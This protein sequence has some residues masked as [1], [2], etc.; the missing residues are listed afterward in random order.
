MQKHT[1]QGETIDC[2]FGSY[3]VLSGVYLKCETGKVVGLLG[4]NGSGKSTL[5]KVLFG[6]LQSESGTVRWNGQYVKQAFEVQNLIKFMS[7]QPGIP[8]HLTFNRLARLLK[9]NG[10]NYEWAMQNGFISRHLN[11]PFHKVSAGGRK[12]MEAFLYLLTES[13]FVLLDEP[14]SY[15]SSLRVEELMS[16]IREQSKTKGIMLT[17][18]Q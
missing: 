8:G 16:I 17:D 5:L 12:L 7:Q 10:Q 6:S 18:H 15:L 4:R 14:F 11:I 1:L 2:C 9:I 13:R 3:K